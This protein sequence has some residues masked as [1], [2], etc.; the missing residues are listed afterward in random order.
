MLWTQ[1]NGCI[2]PQYLIWFSGLVTG[3]A[4]RLYAWC[5]TDLIT[6][7]EPEIANLIRFTNAY[8]FIFG[9]LLGGK[10]WCS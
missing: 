4:T 5:I 6:E 3:G 2:H 1:Y 7:A 10:L 8:N 9:N